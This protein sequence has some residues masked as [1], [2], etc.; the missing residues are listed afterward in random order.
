MQF[1]GLAIKPSQP[2]AVDESAVRPCV[3]PH[4]G[5]RQRDL[6]AP[7]GHEPRC[8][9]LTRVLYIYGRPGEAPAASP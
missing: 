9:H 6:C 5:G 3:G 1:M 4:E 2:S 7:T 8:L